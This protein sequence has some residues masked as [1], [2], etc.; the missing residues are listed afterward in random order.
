MLKFKKK[1]FWQCWNKTLFWAMLKLN[2]LFTRESSKY[3]KEIYERFGFVWSVI[4][5]GVIEIKDDFAELKQKAFKTICQTKTK[6]IK[7]IL[8]YIKS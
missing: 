5:S 1:Y 2:N 6:S 7:T 3:H 4:Q 8:N